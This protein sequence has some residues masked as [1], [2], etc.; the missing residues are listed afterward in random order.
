MRKLGGVRTI[1]V[2]GRSALDVA[3]E[4]AAVLA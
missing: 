3:G 2:T 1:D 4:I